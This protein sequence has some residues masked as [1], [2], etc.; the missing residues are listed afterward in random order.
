MNVA[1]NI[2]GGAPAP[3]PI[4]KPKRMSLDSLREGRI[5][6]PP[7]VCIYGPEKIGKST[8]ASGAPK[9]IFIG[10]DSGTE[11]LDIKRMP[12]PETWAE[13]MEG[14]REVEARGKKMG[15]ET[16]VV[17]PVNWLEPLA[18]ADILGPKGGSL[19][20]FEGGY[21]RGTNALADRWRAFV[22]AVE[23]V[24]TSGMGVVIVAHCR[25]KQFNNPLGKNWTRYEMAFAETGAGMIR[26]WVDCIL[27]AEREAGA[28]HEG[29][30][31]STGH[32]FL[33]TRPNAGFD[34]GNRWDLPPTLPMSWQALSAAKLSFEEKDKS[35]RS[36]IEQLIQAIGDP[37]VE[38]QARAFLADT[39]TTSRLVEIVN[40]LQKKLSEKEKVNE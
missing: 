3:A 36:Q 39:I 5:S 19:D 15:F 33:H 11:H 13:L 10:K 31:I 38:K 2:N 1:A 22:H 25:T 4:A 20:K 6:A 40:G 29:K 32:V 30:G 24:W 17:D 8:F 28:N 14:I 34:A 18:I 16:L 27:F 26:Q 7:R 21:G 9:P 37:V 35:L 23:A 12:Q